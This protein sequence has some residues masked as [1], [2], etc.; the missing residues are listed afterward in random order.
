MKKKRVV[1]IAIGLLLAGICV[2]IAVIHVADQREEREVQMIELKRNY[3]IQNDI[4]CTGYSGFNKYAYA[5]Y[6]EGTERYL[7]IT[8]CAYE[9]YTGQT[10]TLEDVKAF[11]AQPIN[12]DGSPRTYVD[13]ETGII[14]DLIT[15]CYSHTAEI[16]G[17]R[18][19]LTRVINTY[20][21]S[22]PDLGGVI[23]FDLSLDQIYML[24]KKMK[25]PDFDLDLG[26]VIY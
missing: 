4:L 12:P 18:N 5:P 24:E 25:D 2:L 14:R 1:F 7:Q 26:D 10:V 22:H 13:D 6:Y 3:R 11:L 20:V 15:W 17:Y 21:V 23:L 8:L 9:Y 19:E 16:N